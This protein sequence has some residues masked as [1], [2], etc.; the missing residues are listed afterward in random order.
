MLTSAIISAVAKLT[1]E[2]HEHNCLMLHPSVARG[3]HMYN[4][5]HIPRFE[6]LLMND[7]IL[8]EKGHSIK[9]ET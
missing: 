4:I 1:R 7:F 3:S 9:V 6:D 8:E 2:L 5:N